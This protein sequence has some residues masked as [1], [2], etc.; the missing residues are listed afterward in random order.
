[1]KRFDVC[2]I[3]GGPAGY[4]AAMRALGFDKKVV[5]KNSI[6]MDILNGLVE[7]ISGTYQL[8]SNE[9]VTL[10]KISFSKK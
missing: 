8:T 3:G 5:S 10:Y 2:I 4:A 7:Q 6:G 9:K 1:M